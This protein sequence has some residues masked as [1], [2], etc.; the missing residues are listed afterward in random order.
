[1]DAY[2]ERDRSGDAR[3]VYDYSLAVERQRRIQRIWVAVLIV[4]ALGHA[5][6]CAVTGGGWPW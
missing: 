2:R 4:S 5:A 6:L 1:M 3:L